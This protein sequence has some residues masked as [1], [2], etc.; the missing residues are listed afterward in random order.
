MTEILKILKVL[1]D[2]T[3]LRIIRCLS[4]AELSVAEIV[5]ALNLPQSTISRHLKPLKEVGLI[6]SRRDGTSVFYK[7]EVLYKDKELKN[8]LKEKLKYIPSAERDSVAV[9]KII[10]LRNNKS[11]SFFDKIAGNYTSLTEPG[12]GWDALSTALGVGF[13]NKRIVDLGCGEGD[14]SLILSRYAKNITCVDQSKKMLNLIREKSKKVK[15]KSNIE[16]IH[17]NIDEIIL[18]KNSYDLVIISQSLHHV[19]YPEKV[20]SMSSDALVSGGKIIILDLIS[21][22]HEWTKEQWADQWLGFSLDNIEDWLTI[23]NFNCITLDSLKGSTPDL[24]V[25]IAIGEKI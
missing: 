3:R 22:N 5:I 16:L 21:H 19:S 6:N 11:L 7:L 13:H 15:I 23:N 20:I 9:D 17:K 8:F 12:G 2:E 14:I 1:A 18:K 10:D 25:L 24:P 4:Q